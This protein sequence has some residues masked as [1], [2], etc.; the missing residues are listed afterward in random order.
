MEMVG[1]KSK[2]NIDSF[3]LGGYKDRLIYSYKSLEDGYEYYIT[4]NGITNSIY[5]SQASAILCNQMYEDRFII[6]EFSAEEQ[7]SF[8]IKQI[9]RSSEEILFRAD[10]SGMPTV[11]VIGDYLLVN[12][13]LYNDGTAEQPIIIY[14]LKTKASKVIGRYKYFK[15]AKGNYDGNLLQA[16]EGFENGI[17]FEI[18]NFNDEDINPD[19]TGKPELFY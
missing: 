3:G 4:V 7:M 15:N 12:Y 10:C 2:N 9:S 5:T 14:N 18:I 17:I 6:C 19:E 13:G 8:I 11:E 16:A 1:K